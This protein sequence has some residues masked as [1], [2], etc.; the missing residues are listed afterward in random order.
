MDALFVFG[1]VALL[2]VTNWIAV[3]VARLG[4]IE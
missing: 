1:I 4:R 2:V 3:A